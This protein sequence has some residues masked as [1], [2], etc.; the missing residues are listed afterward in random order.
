[1]RAIFQSKFEN[2]DMASVNNNLKLINSGKEYYESFLFIIDHMKKIDSEYVSV[3]DLH[4]I[5]KIKLVAPL[6]KRMLY[7][8]Y[9]DGIV[10]GAGSGHDCIDLIKNENWRL[11]DLQDERMI[12]NAIGYKNCDLEFVKTGTT[13]GDTITNVNEKYS[14][15]TEKISMI[16]IDSLEL[17][18]LSFLSLDVEGS[19][20]DVLSGAAQTLLK[21][22][23]DL[24]VSIYHNSAEYLL[25]VPF[26][27]DFGYEINVVKTSNF[28][29][30]QPHLEL[31]L[32]CTWRGI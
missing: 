28:L 17:E 2:I 6:S 4:D 11:F 32:L 19:A 10:V 14:K 3:Y 8:K 9:D 12:K 24:L 21:C 31:S 18:K 30:W 13:D 20:M 7:S 5:L 26:L 27:Y 22:K 1:M 15:G 23:P 25:S 29:P 16:T